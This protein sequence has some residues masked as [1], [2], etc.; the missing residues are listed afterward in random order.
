MYIKPYPAATY[1]SLQRDGGDDNSGGGGLAPV[2]NDPPA[3][4]AWS[5]VDPYPERGGPQARQEAHSR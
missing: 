5:P 4:V 3:Q 2:L 1:A